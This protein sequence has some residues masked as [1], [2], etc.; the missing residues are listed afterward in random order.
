MLTEML[1]VGE[2]TLDVGEKTLGK[3]TSRRNDRN[4]SVHWE[5][6][7]GL[8]ECRLCRPNLSYVSQRYSGEQGTLIYRKDSCISRTCV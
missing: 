2:S 3:T 7:P 4:S 5:C 1:Y 6:C 8:N